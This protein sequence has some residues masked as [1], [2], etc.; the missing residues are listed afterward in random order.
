MPREKWG[1]Q[2]T[3]FSHASGGVSF[4]YNNLVS[5]MRAL[6]IM[7]ETG[8]PVVF[9]ATHSSVQLPGEQSLSSGGQSEFVPVLARAAITTGVAGMFMEHT[10]NPPKQ[11][12]IV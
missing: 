5:D 10:H 2:K 8:A 4:G 12:R 1:F 11:S 9:N 7:R 6:A 3:D